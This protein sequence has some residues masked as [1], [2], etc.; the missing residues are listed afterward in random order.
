MSVLHR[1]D[2]PTCVNPAHLFLG[3]QAEN[4]ADMM[5][6]G[7]GL[8]GSRSPRAKLT[9]EYVRLIRVAVG[10]RILGVRPLARVFGVSRDTVKAVI[11]GRTWAAA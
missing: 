3:T 4:M 11:E 2:V 7:R 5:A 1:C 9:P 8:R 6:K 10:C